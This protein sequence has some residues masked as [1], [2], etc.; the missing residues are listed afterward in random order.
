MA[1]VY[2]YNFGCSANLADGERMLGCLERAGHSEASTPEEADILIY[3]TCAVKGPTEDRMISLLKAAPKDKKVLVAGCLPLINFERLRREVDFNG[4]VGPAASTEIVEA[5]NRILRGEKPIILNFNSKP[6]V[7]LP[8][9]PSN[10]VR[11]IIPVAYGCLSSCS[12]CC[13]RIARGRLRSYTIEEVKGQVEQAVR[14][15]VREIW[16]T[17]QDLA[18]YGLDQGLSLAQLLREV[19]E[20]EG[21]FYVRVG[22]MNPR[23]LLSQAEEVA[24]AFQHPKIFK[25]LHLPVQSGDDEVLRLMNRGYTSG[26]FKAIVNVFRRKV[27]DLTLAT[28]IIC[29]FPGETEEAFQNTLR[30]LEEVKPDIVNVSKFYPRPGTPAKLMEKL[31]T[32]LVKERSR[33]LTAL[34]GKIALERN[35]RWLGWEGEILIDEHGLHGTMVGRNYAYKPI[36]V[37]EKL[38]LGEMVRVKISKS[39]QNYLEGE[40]S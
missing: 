12:Y 13:V 25:F 16:L 28:D 26:D 38:K 22:M 19:V 7:N 11:R 35:R 3:N 5:V 15:G 34:A 14:A 10:P 30:L 18:C 24:E 29:G 40:I 27:P 4:V 39:F 21:C 2:L 36:V 8:F 33:M 20:V 17:G 31:P 23:F 37:N 6:E 32:K 1:K 9:K